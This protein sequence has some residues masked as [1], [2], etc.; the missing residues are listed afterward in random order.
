MDVN[1][2][3]DGPMRTFQVKLRGAGVLTP[4]TSGGGITRAHGLPLSCLN[5]DCG[6]RWRSSSNCDVA[7]GASLREPGTQS[8]SEVSHT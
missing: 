7:D 5:A 6:P 1:V 3:E 8:Q 4:C 2:Y